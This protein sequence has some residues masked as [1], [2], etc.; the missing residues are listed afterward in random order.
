M[1]KKILLFLM[2]LF[3]S[4]G[5]EARDIDGRPGQYVYAK[6]E[7]QE[8][9]E[10]ISEWE[11]VKKFN[12]EIPGD[13]SSNIKYEGILPEY[14]SYV[15]VLSNRIN[16]R[17]KPTTKSEILSKAVSGTRLQV[18][19]EVKNKGGEGWYKVLRDGSEV[20]VYKKIVALREF[21]FERSK[22]RLERLE[23][24]IT[25]NIS[26]GREIASVNSYLPNPDNKGLMR[27][28]DKYG[29]VEDQSA[30]GDYNGTKVFVADRTI[31]A[32]HERVADKYRVEKIGGEEPFLDIVTYRISKNPK[33]DEMPK[34]AIV[35][36]IKNQNFIVYEKEE[37]RWEIIS[38]ALS[39]TGAESK[40]G[41]RTPRGEFIVPMAKRVMIYNDSEGE[42]QGYANYAIRFS[43]GG[44]IH[45][46]PFNL[47]EEEELERHRKLKESTLGSY[48][49][50]RKCVR[51]DI[52][53]ARFLFEW[54]VGDV[55]GS[56][57]HQKVEEN[58]VVIVM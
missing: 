1:K 28:R 5:G 13:I 16:V 47:E 21:R 41:F 14:L 35:I 58:V 37:D 55:E 33:I 15:V 22:E 19:E 10:K 54:V 51:N 39:K 44:Y 25:E 48:P 7:K 24:F 40:L 6:E 11:V 17:E 43:G 45:G 12:K 34:K 52:I 30:K 50:T 31:V 53:H 57:N 3:V 42:K 56:K 4:L 38:Y 18:V 2:L 36:D 27:E 26:E 29:N 46:T 8:I 23:K 9:S 49:G 20:F 32:I